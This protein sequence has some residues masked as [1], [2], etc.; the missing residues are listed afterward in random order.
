MYDVEQHLRMTV[1]NLSNE[2]AQKAVTIAEQQ[3][4]IV[5]QGARIRQLEEQV[6]RDVEPAVEAEVAEDP[7]AVN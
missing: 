1:Q 5:A 4:Q 3:A 7:A 2:I 6:S